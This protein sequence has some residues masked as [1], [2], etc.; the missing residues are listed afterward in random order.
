[1]PSGSLLGRLRRVTT[2]ERIEWK[3]NTAND[4]CGHV[5]DLANKAGGIDVSHLEVV[6]LFIIFS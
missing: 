1:M 3:R 6:D 4:L 5:G 2:P